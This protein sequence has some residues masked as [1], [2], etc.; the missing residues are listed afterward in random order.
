MKRR[1]LLQTAAAAALWPAWA[2]SQAPQNAVASTT[3]IAATFG[4]LPPPARIQRVFA[5][6]APAGV[7]VAA[8]A[9]E[10]LLGW[11]MQLNAAAR[12]ALGPV[13]SALPFL[14]RLAG[15]GSTVSVETLLQLRPDV[16]LDA[17]TADATYVSAARRVS[18]Q[19]GLPTLLV[20]GRLAE[21]AAQLREVG[22]LLGVPEHAER[23]AAYADATIALAA[24]VRAS[25]PAAQRPGV[26]YGR[27]A[28]GL[29]TGLDGSINVELLDFA[30]GRNV[31]AA[32]G[33][34]S[35]TRVSLE[36]ILA[37]NPEVIVTQ[38]PEFAHRVRSDPLWRAIRAVQTGRVHCAPVLPFGWLDGPPGVNRLIGVHWLLARLHPAH[39][40]VRAQETLSQAAQRF[41]RLFY[42][43]DLTLAA[44]A[45]LLEDV[46]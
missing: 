8:L 19:T 32:A 2:R 13:P 9:P 37:W 28:D 21:H 18:E 23:L 41:Y 3:T 5:A 15:R 24:Q 31:A 25:V 43:T 40:A 36:Q 26:Y 33:K 16:I 7:L 1:Q 12:A 17:G 27:G 38:E 14:G 34:G 30:G 45:T 35:I 44:A 22:R 39:P 29:E 6:G 42:G 11:P 46:R 20:Q 10:K 4:A